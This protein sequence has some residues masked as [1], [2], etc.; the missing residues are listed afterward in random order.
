MEIQTFHVLTDTALDEKVCL[1]V[2]VFPKVK[3]GSPTL[4]NSRRRTILVFR[5]GMCKGLQRPYLMKKS[6]LNI[7]VE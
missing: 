4:Y 5:G 7:L 3:T 1:R 2:L 6:L